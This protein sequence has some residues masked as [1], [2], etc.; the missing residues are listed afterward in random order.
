[1]N[2]SERFSVWW[3]SENMSYDVRMVEVEGSCLST[4]AYHCEQGYGVHAMVQ[5]FVGILITE[6]T[7]G[8]G[9][10]WRCTL[11]RY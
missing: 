2:L 6:K 7:E 3:L 1:M 9:W 10:C 11:R 5:P 4:H 8:I